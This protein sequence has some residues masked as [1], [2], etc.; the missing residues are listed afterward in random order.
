MI[1]VL[2]QKC[3]DVI[4]V[5]SD[6]VQGEYSLEGF[7]LC[8]FCLDGWYFDFV[9]L[10]ICIECLEGFKCFNKNIALIQCGLGEYR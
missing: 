10:I 6:C 2:G 4:V 5:V 8:Y 3:L 7:F 9:K 1:Y